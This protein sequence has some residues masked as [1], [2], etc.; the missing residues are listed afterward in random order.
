MYEWNDKRTDQ[1]RAIGRGNVD[2]E[3]VA[4]TSGAGW[5]QHRDSEMISKETY[6]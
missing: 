6:Y 3:E 1:W 5:D 4:S 2:E